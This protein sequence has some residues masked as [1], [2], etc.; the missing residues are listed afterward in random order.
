[1]HRAFISFIAKHERSWATFKEHVSRSIWQKSCRSDLAEFFAG[2]AIL[3]SE[4]ALERVCKLVMCM[5]VMG[6]GIK[7]KKGSMT[8]TARL[9]TIK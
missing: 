7:K 3:P 9:G 8:F 6:T 4:N 1:M 2:Q 5:P